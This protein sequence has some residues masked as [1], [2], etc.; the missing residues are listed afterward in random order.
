MV[1]LEEVDGFLPFGEPEF[2]LGHYFRL[3]AVDVVVFKDGPG[4]LNGLEK[5]VARD[6]NFLEKVPSNVIIYG[7]LI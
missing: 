3:A 4:R 5:G 1:G 6:D 2:G 7:F